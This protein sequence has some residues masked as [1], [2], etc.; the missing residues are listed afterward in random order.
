MKFSEWNDSFSV[1]YPKI[2]EQHKVVFDIIND[3]YD[4]IMNATSS[5][6]IEKIV[7]KMVDYTRYHFGE[8]EI[9]FDQFE[10]EHKALHE[11]EHKKFVKKSEEF[12]ASVG[13]N[14]NLLS[15]Q[16]LNFLR[17]W[18]IKHILYHDKKYVNKLY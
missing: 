18:W 14:D 8:E 2:D 4:S 11:I 12:L 7:E 13:K 15:I 3:L 9:L 5:N 1:G 16:V 6:I 10:Y 17:D